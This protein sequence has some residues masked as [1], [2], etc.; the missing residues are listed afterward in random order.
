M[1]SRE[2]EVAEKKKILEEGFEI[3][4]TKTLE[5]EVSTMCNLSKGVE[6]KG[7]EKGILFSIKS[8]METMG[9]SAEQAMGG[10]KIP[11][12]ERDKY[13]TELKNERDYEEKSVNKNL[14]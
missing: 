10:L 3:E 12:S 8:L 6:E 13:I 2:R 11:E 14:L 9:W 5:S 4:M 1:L 7:I